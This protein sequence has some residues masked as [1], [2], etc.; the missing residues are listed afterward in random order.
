MPL[1]TVGDFT[2]Y[3]G[4]DEADA[5]AEGALQAD[6]WRA[7]DDD[8]K[9]RALV[10]ATRIFDRQRWKGDKTVAN[11]DLAWPRSN[12]GIDTVD[13]AVIPEDITNGSI[14]LAF[15]LVDG[16]TVQYD[17]NTSQKIQS[18]QAGS[19]SLS[20]FRGADGIPI[21]WPLPVQELIRDYLAGG[22]LTLAGPISSGVDGKSVTR[23]D[24]GLDNAR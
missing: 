21:R 10:T 15:A 14:E 13:P 22:M 18:M 11:Q 16:S 4:T 23:Q 2:V 17:Q 7:A 3:A 6:P 5:Y 19:V 24:F 8:T 9:G 1:P 12:T 20:F